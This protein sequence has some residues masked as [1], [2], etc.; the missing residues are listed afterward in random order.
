MTKN[1]EIARKIVERVKITNVK[2]SWDLNCIRKQVLQAL[3]AKDTQGITVPRDVLEE[4][5]LLI[6][7]QS[8]DYSSDITGKPN[9]R[10]QAL[11]KLEALLEG[12]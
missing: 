8:N 4:C 6:A 3:D 1:E 11:A 9:R 12:K 5:K 2:N 10:Q 7:Y